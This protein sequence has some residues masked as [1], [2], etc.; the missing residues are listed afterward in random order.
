M[1]NCDIA[2][3]S[4][5]ADELKKLS[6]NSDV[7]VRIAV[8]WNKNTASSVLSSLSKDKNIDVRKRCCTQ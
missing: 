4:A 7:D 3:N 2:D 6:K 5:N 8:A 1:N